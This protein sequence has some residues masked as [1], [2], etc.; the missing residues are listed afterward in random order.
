MS[1]LSYIMPYLMALVAG[2]AGPR[3]LADAAVDECSGKFRSARSLWFC[4][5][6]S[7]HNGTL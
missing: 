7:K 4:F 3:S 6:F 2:G 5:N 1:V